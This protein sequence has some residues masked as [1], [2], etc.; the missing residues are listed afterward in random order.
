MD[1]QKN[2]LFL[3]KIKEAAHA[4]H[5]SPLFH[6]FL[7]IFLSHVSSED[8]GQ[9]AV[10]EWVQ[11]ISSLFHFFDAQQKTAYPVKVY[12]LPAPKS[13]KQ[14]HRT[15]IEIVHP[16]LPF[17]I[18]SLYAALVSKGHHIS[19]FLHFILRPLKTSQ[20]QIQSLAEGKAVLGETGI[21]SVLHIQLE[22]ALSASDQGILQDLLITVI[23]DVGSAVHDWQAMRQCIH[24]CITEI[25]SNPLLRPEEKAEQHHF[26]KWLDEGFLTF[27]GYR[28]YTSASGPGLQRALGVAKT[29]KGSF[30]GPDE[31][32]EYAILSQT[33]E[34]FPYFSIT[35]TMVESKVHRPVPMDVVRLTAFDEKGN[36]IGEH[37]FFGLFAA[38]VYNARLQDIPFLQTKISQVLT[39]CEVQSD[40]YDGRRLV[41]LL[42]SLPRDLLFQIPVKELAT[43]AQSILRLKER[44]KLSLFVL[45]DPLGHFLWSLIY[46]PRDRYTSSLEVDMGEMLADCY[47]GALISHETYIGGD[48]SFARLHYIVSTDAHPQHTIVCDLHS[49]EMMLAEL[50]LSWEEQFKKA[51]KETEPENPLDLSCLFSSAY[52]NH[53]SV[54]EALKDF[55]F[56]KKSLQSPSKS[57]RVYQDLE[58]GTIH[59]KIF[60]PAHPLFLSDIF[61]TLENMGLRILTEASYTLGK[62]IHSVWLHHFTAE[63]SHSQGEP[64][65]K[66]YDHFVHV[67]E[68]VLE[69]KAEDD[70]FNKLVLVGNLSARHLLLMRAY[71]HYM[72]QIGWSFLPTSIVSVL[73]KHPSILRKLGQ[74]FYA[75]FSPVSEEAGAESTLLS[76]LH[77][78]LEKIDN[79]EDESILVGFLTLIRATQRTNFFQLDLEGQHKNYVS[80][81]FLPR[82]IEP[83]S[84]TK[85][86]YEVFVYAPWVEAI[87]LRSG[88]VA[89]GGIRWSDRRMDYR[90]EVLELMKAQLVKNAVIV[91]MGAKG[92]FYVKTPVDHLSFT[93]RQE[94]GIHAYKT[95]V[96]GL[97]D[98][99]DNLIEGQVVHPSSVVCRDGDDPYLVVAADK[100]TATFSDIANGLSKEYGFWL[101]DAFASGGSAGYDHKKIG[102]TSRG[103]W[104][105]VKRH[106]RELGRD[107]QQPFTVV[108]VGDMSGDVFGNGMLLSD[109][110]QLIAAFNHSHIFID[111]TPDTSLS[112]QERKRLFNLPRSQWS[113][114]NSALLSQGGG[115]FERKVKSIRLSKEA[116]E[117][118]QL[119]E[120]DIKPDHL[121]QHIL[122]LPVDL[123]WFGGI[124][125]YVK[126]RKETDAEVGDRTNDAVRV[127]GQEIRAKIIGE[128]ANLGLTQKG[129]MAYAF[130]GGKINRDSVDN[131]GGVDCSDHEVNIKILFQSILKSGKLSEDERNALLKEMTA[132]VALLVIH[133][134][135]LQ[136]QAISVIE[137]CGVRVL[138]RQNRLIRLFESHERFNREQE[139]L[140]SEEDIEQR[141]E[142]QIGLTRPEIAV[143]VSH[144]K[145]YLYEKILE[146]SLPE[147]P[148]LQHHLMAYFPLPLQQ[149]YASFI[150]QH[151]LRREL[152]ATSEANFLVNRLGTTTLFELER[153]LN[154][155]LIDLIAFFAQG[156]KVFGLEP[157]WQHIESLDGKIPYTIQNRL[158]C[159]LISFSEK[160][161]EWYALNEA[162][163]LE[164]E[165]DAPKWGIGP[166]YRVDEKKIELA[167]TFILNLKIERG[168]VDV[169]REW[170]VEF[171]EIF[172]G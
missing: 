7:S 110:I 60:N 100:G 21:D 139:S 132:E 171:K 23:R 122:K 67:L 66:T 84:D 13:G 118:L 15:V 77:E 165:G 80:L 95:M 34:T 37:Q 142:K 68:Q 112:Y 151:P 32:T 117:L 125:T 101:G 160:L 63:P 41:Y 96:R 137:S 94:V 57:L 19:L 52:Q 8:L 113:D 9:Y 130:T 146:S 48:L 42:E 120:E 99:T 73:E 74:L 97:L 81:K 22:N 58:E 153:R 168:A 65:E 98:I 14:D 150:Q 43:F 155:P 123:L 135:Y 29:H 119:Q 82:L 20:G 86:L 107:I 103:A 70:L 140:P 92:G 172:H 106:F 45:P 59:L 158:F 27:L 75:Q 3:Q 47:K 167:E 164:K 152:I 79:S 114:Y 88:Q 11:L 147:E 50:S 105:S 6:E 161:I 162:M 108:G 55:P 144:A 170:L 30:F 5:S 71:A 72:R 53:F 169:F 38:A 10:E 148:C 12:N 126:D 78:D 115:V 109:Q 44:H 2:S 127:N 93:E 54:R 51:Y 111:P 91:P 133:S 24:F 141:L 76:S 69:K 39:R 134:N 56:V 131:S 40:W 138:A 83:L 102:I 136:T 64:F 25:Q 87:H 17:L 62:G 49:T 90:K 143:L 1:Q 26:F 166:S 116:K 145:L 163:P 157:C 104:E 85:P 121:I 28:F 61:P 18:D 4:S 33:W 128:G 159:L 156:R 16:H 124:G 31:R 129:R 46:V 36:V 35:K 89:R 149:K 154:K